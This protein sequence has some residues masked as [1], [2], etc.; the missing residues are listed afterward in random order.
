MGEFG[1]VFAAAG[2]KIVDAIG[3]VREEVLDRDIRQ[4]YSLIN[5]TVDQ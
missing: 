3:T 1:A 4:S 2:A 5:Q